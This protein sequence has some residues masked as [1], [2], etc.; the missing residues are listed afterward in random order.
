MVVSSFLAADIPLHKQ[1]HPSLKSLLL[2]R[3][4][5]YLLRLQPG[6]VLLYYKHVYIYYNSGSQTV[7]RL[8]QGRR[9]S[10]RS[11]CTYCFSHNNCSVKVVSSNVPFRERFRSRTFF[12]FREHPDFGREIGKSEMKSK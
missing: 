8:C 9:E 5:Y 2:Q 11:C 6:Q 12:F 7:P 4:K 10:M 3:E 1:N